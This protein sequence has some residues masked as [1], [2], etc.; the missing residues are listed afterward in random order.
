MIYIYTLSDPYTNEIKYVGK[1][2]GDIR[3]RWYAHCS[4][5]KLKK[6]KG[7]KS[8]WI[9]GLL[10]KG[11]KPIIEIIDIV[12]EE[13]WEFWE[14]YWISQVKSWGFNLTNMTKGG[15]G[16]NGG[17]GCLGY[18]H[19]EEAKKRISKKNSRPKSQEWIENAANAVR[20]LTAK[21]IVQIDIKTNQI[22]KEYISFY[23][24]AKY[25]NTA[26]NYKST[27]KNIHA[28]CNKRRKTAYG[29]IWK[30]KESIEL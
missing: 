5:Y 19:T 11:K 3:K 23:E 29:Y 17:K 8:S 18:K 14:I 26:G 24:A 21:P 9:M 12:E 7:L 27:I 6:H 13:N 22:I 10:N 15:E 2:K 30:Y 25:I 1:T 20:K 16:G 28:C 4:K